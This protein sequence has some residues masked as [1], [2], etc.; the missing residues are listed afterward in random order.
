MRLPRPR[1]RRTGSKNSNETSKPHYTRQVGIV[2]SVRG[3]VTFHSLL[4]VA[5]VVV[6][7]TTAVGCHLEST[8]AKGSH[9]KENE[10]NQ[11]TECWH[12]VGYSLYEAN[13]NQW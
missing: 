13:E 9:V 5:Q 7:V 1:Q 11:G 6:F 10:T 8:T 2:T 4:E 12:N 3:A